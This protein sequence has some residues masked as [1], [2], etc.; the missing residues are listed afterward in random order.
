MQWVIK[1]ALLTICISNIYP[2]FI[3]LKHFSPT[4]WR[5]KH[6]AEMI[7]SMKENTIQPGMK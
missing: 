2:G 4:D 1:A 5:R 6:G 7:H 3:G